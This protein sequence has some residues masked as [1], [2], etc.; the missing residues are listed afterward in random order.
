MSKTRTGGGVI[1]AGGDVDR[2]V[3]MLMPES[4]LSSRA[5]RVTSFPAGVE[6][7]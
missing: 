2:L 4:A 1:G 6:G 3:F 7:T 5:G